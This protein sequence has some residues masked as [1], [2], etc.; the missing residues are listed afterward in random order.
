M[1]SIFS[2]KRLIPGMRELVFLVLLFVVLVVFFPVAKAHS[3]DLDSL[4]E[5]NH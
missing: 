5:E 3:V 4:L 1:K 2:T